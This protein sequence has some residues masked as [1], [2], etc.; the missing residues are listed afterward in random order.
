MFQLFEDRFLFAFVSSLALPNYKT[1]C[2]CNLLRYVVKSVIVTAN[3]LDDILILD[4]ARFQLL[5]IK[6][7]QQ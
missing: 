5:E 6:L 7:L 2:L 1:F 4:D 3:H